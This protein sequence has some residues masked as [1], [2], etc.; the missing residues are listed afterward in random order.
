MVGRGRR[1]ML[2]LTSLAP[3]VGT[4]PIDREPPRHANQ[5]GAEP[6]AIAQLTEPAVRPHERFLRHLFGVLP[7]PQHAERDAEG[8]RRRFDQPRLEFVLELGVH[9]DQI[10]RQAF[11]VF[12]HRCISRRSGRQDAAARVRVQWLAR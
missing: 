3:P 5:P 1:V 4:A 6:I 11:G 2:L 8:E 7:M 10:A 12:V 9:R